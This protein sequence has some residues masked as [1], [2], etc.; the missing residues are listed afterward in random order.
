[1]QNLFILGIK[2]SGKTTFAR[3]LANHLSLTS[4]DSDDLILNSIAPFTVR[5]YYKKFGSDEFK[6]QEYAS[7]KRFIREQDHPFIMSLG[8][9]ACDNKAL[10]ELLKENGKLIYLRRN[11]E[12]MLPVILKHGIPAFLDE[13]NLKSSFHEVYERRDKA[14]SSLADKIIEM[15]PYRD[16]G[17]TLSM[18]INAL[19]DFIA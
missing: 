11:E 14:Y 10:I 4:I 7:V 3:L 2:H 1:M 8:G 17:E 13:N 6:K 18:M 12:E 15:G 16:R 5:E 9:G 19:G